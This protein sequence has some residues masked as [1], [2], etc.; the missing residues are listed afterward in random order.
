MINLST[1]KDKVL[2]EAHRVLRPGGR[3]AVSD[4]VL[5][6]PLEPRWVSVVGLWTGCVSGALIVDEYQAKLT[7]G[8]FGN[9]R[10]RS[11]TPGTRRVGW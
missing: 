8:G 10:S 2:T 5:L 11:P 1:D 3:F 4:I 6:R 7:T 9:P